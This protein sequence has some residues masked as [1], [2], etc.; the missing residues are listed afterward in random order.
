MNEKD[1]KKMFPRSSKYDKDWVMENSY[2]GLTLH[3]LESLTFLINLKKG[4]RVLDLGCGWAISSIFLAKE[5]GVQV[6]A[7][8]KNFSPSENYVRVKEARCAENVFPLKA[9]A[10]YLPFP[11]D[12]FDA[13][14][15]VDAYS[16]FGMDERYPSYL[17]SFLKKGG[18]IAIMD[19]CFTREFNNIKEVPE[20][21]VPIY[22]DKEDPW[23]PVHSVEWWRNF[24]EKSG[25][26]KVLNAEII[27]ETE[28]IWKKYRQNCSEIKSEQKLIKALEKDRGQNL[29]LLRLKAE[30]K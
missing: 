9:D 28:A 19:G 4:M 12:F 8:D 18:I 21:I 1:L 27:P 17:A 24:L 30:K 14:I 5:Y 23:Y 6:W 10:R 29:A 15:S 26:I 2:D 11:R 20:H 13:V 3:C 16:Y 25:E 7:V 22:N